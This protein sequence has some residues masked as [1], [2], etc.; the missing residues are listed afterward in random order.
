MTSLRETLKRA[1]PREV[2]E[3]VIAARRRFAAPPL[4]EIVLHAYEIAREASAAPRISLVIPDVSPAKAF[5]GVTTGLDIFF[6]VG[7]RTGAE[8]RVILD[9]FGRKVDRTIVDR[10]ASAAGVTPSEVEVLPRER[11][12]PVVGVRARDVFFTFNWWTTLNVRALVEAQRRAFGGERL[13]QIYISQEYEPGAYPFSSTHMMARLALD[14]GDP[15]WGVFN[16]GELARF[17]EGQGHR[18]T[19]AF[20]FEPKLA[21]ALRPFLEGEAPEK[22]RRILVYGRP[23]IERNCFPAVEKALRLWAERHPEFADWEVV[24]AGLPHP[25][26]PIAPGLAMTSL[27]MLSLEDYAALL[28]TSAVGLS[29]MA[30][31][32]P[33]YPP[34][35]MAHFGLLTV[36]NTYACKDLAASHPN[37]LSAPDISP[38]TI[39]DTLARA[40]R[41]FEA[42]PGAGW[43]AVTTRPS[44]LEPGPLACLD[45]LAQALREMWGV[46]VPSPLAGEGSRALI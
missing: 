2:R 1:L 24:S 30:S 34:L 7:K 17:V 9:D 4:E 29:L 15:R 22:A 8:M 27:G 44:F 32:H 41:A 18:M 36:T 5:G 3:A 42:N 38:E 31:P 25:P 10:R 43:Q 39:A 20:V 23:S 28:R 45:D 12:V 37:I 16:S 13:P 46:N 21:P 35:E 40:C 14:A 11:E 26:L 33:S 6:E 19:R